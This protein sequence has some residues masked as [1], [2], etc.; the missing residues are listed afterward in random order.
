MKTKEVLQ[1]M[2]VENT[3][4][5]FMDSGDAYGRHW[6]RNQGVDFES[7][8][9]ATL[10]F[11]AYNGRLYISFTLDAYHWLSERLSYSEELDKL[12]HGRFR[13]EV[14]AKDD[15]S[16][17]ELMEEFPEWLS[18]L[19]NDG[20]PDE[21]LDE[22]AEVDSDSDEDD[23][24]DEDADF[25]LRFGE[26]GGIYGDGNPITVNTYNGEDAL[27]QT[28]QYTLFSGYAGDFVALQ[29]HGGADVRGG[30]TKPRVFE[31]GH[32]SEL[33]ILDNARGGI[34][35]TGE[36][37][38]PGVLS[39]KEA[40]EKQL[41]IPGVEVTKIDFDSSNHNWSTDDAGYSWY[42]QGSCGWGAGIQLEKYEVVDLDDEEEAETPW[43][44]GKLF[45]KDGSGFCPHCGAKL[46]ASGY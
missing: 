26:F 2:F 33:D 24:S 12:F 1:G 3:G 9:A 41:L 39:L 4:R 6:Q 31:F 17:L 22:D 34:Y 14:D 35:C 18:K 45:I 15:K 8:P 40:Q 7:T 38:L 25:E 46:A 5:H 27:S 23:D 13:K 20:I 16:W 36:D 11:K 19:A 28:L 10:R 30:Y 44:P 21:G 37:Y 43:E 42:Y 32:M 29:V